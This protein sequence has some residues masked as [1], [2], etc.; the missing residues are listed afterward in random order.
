[1]TFAPIILCMEN[2]SSLILTI[3]SSWKNIS[4]SYAFRQKLIWMSCIAKECVPLNVIRIVFCVLLV[5]LRGIRLFVM[6]MG[7]FI[8]HSTLKNGIG[9]LHAA[10]EWR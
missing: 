4:W 8:F 1:M 7:N 5:S 2:G 9:F 10:Q 6:Q 3:L